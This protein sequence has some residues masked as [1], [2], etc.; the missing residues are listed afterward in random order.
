MRQIRCSVVI[1]LD[2]FLA[3]P[4]KGCGWIPEEPA[5]ALNRYRILNAGNATVGVA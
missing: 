1:S 3:D 2:G 5:I 4:D